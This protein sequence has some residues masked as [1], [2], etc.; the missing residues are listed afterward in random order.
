M[1]KSIIGKVNAVAIYI[2]WLF[3]AILSVGLGFLMFNIQTDEVAVLLIS[4]FGG[5]MLFSFIHLILSLFVRCPSCNKC[6][7]AQG[8]RTPKNDPDGRPNNWAYV[9]VR[10][11][12]GAVFCIHCDAKVNTNSL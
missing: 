3:L 2:S 10:W 9:A 5:L 1:N 6:L 8:F 7:T 4:G 12:S 11:F